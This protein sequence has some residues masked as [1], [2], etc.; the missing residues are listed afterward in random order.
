VFRVIHGEAKGAY[1]DKGV[2]DKTV[3]ADA[4]KRSLD[5]EVEDRLPLETYLEMVEMKKWTCPHF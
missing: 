1:W 4:H 5:V 2:T 3:K